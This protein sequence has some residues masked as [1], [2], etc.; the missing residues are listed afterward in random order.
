MIDVA[1]IQ[2]KGGEYVNETAYS[3]WYGCRQLGIETRPF[4]AEEVKTLPLT[5]ETLVHGHIGPVKEALHR[6]GIPE[7]KP[8]VDGMP[9]EDI[10]PYYGRKVWTSTM[11]EIR[12]RW[13]EDRHLFIKPLHVQKAFTGHVTSGQIKDLITTASFPDDFEVLC[14]EPVEFLVEYRCFVHNGTIVDCRRY[15]GDY[16]RVVDIDVTGR[17]VVR[18]YKN[19]PVAYSLDLGLADD[20]RTLVVEVNDAFALGAYGMPSVP[21]A[22]MVIDR[23]EEMVGP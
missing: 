12:T 19:A 14:S 2:K 7:P 23:W 13:S 1:Y 22:A 18:A 11:G 5:K 21:Y 8:R 10:L 20:D 3:F 16:R 17:G 6:L 4:E 9:S 15:R